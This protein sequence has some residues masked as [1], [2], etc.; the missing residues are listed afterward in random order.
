[1]RLIT[2]ARVGFLSRSVDC[3]A[4]FGQA[5]GVALGGGQQLPVDQV[6]DRGVN[7]VEVVKQQAREG[8]RVDLALGVRRVDDLVLKLGELHPLKSRARVGGAVRSA[9]FRFRFNSGDGFLLLFDF[10]RAV[11][12][13]FGDGICF[14][15]DFTW[16][17]TTG[18]LI[19]AVPSA[20]IFTVAATSKR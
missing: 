7:V 12:Y 18:H 16:R 3:L 2:S 4:L 9:G 13:A 17:Q 1:M 15:A 20:L 14:S 8:S 5:V 19:A 10:I 6:T 11:L